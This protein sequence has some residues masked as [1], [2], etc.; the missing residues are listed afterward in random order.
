M[1]SALRYLHLRDNAILS[2]VRAAPPAMT[3]MWHRECSGQVFPHA[4]GHVGA[5]ASTSCSRN[6]SHG[7]TEKSAGDWYTGPKGKDGNSLNS[8]SWVSEE[9]LHRP[10]HA[11][12]SSSS[13]NVTFNDMTG[14]RWGRTVIIISG[15][16]CR[17]ICS[18]TA[19]CG[20]NPDLLFICVVSLVGAKMEVFVLAGGRGAQTELPAGPG[21]QGPDQAGLLLASAEVL[22]SPRRIC[23]EQV[24][25][26]T[27]SAVR[28]KVRGGASWCSVSET[29][30]VLETLTSAWRR[31]FDSWALQFHCCTKKDWGPRAFLKLF[32]NY[33]KVKIK[34]EEINDLWKIIPSAFVNASHLV[35]RMNKRHVIP[36][37]TRFNDPSRQALNFHRVANSQDGLYATTQ[38]DH[39]RLPSL[40]V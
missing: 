25:P 33:K 37:L 12:L 11:S 4:C 3:S 9:W 30:H 16:I 21:R 26:Q 5:T 1:L 39:K 27:A 38:P 7:S 20:K 10:F 2:F 8:C 14:C 24:V 36:D 35:R 28:D 18:H 6:M 23:Q 31:L 13:L 34:V 22:W 40:G 17:G 29:L 19:V 15:Y 32:S